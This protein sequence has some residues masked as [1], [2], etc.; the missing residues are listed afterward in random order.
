MVAMIWML[1]EVT[2][3]LICSLTKYTFC[4]LKDVL[5]CH[6]FIAHAK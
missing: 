2:A 6:V 5:F 3:T 1:K 4:S